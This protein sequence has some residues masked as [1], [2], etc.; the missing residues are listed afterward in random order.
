MSTLTI[1][2]P[3]S[4]LTILEAEA[5]EAY[6]E[7]DMVKR[8]HHILLEALLTSK[9]A[10]NAD[11]VNVLAGLL[12]VGATGNRMSPPVAKKNQFPALIQPTTVKQLAKNDKGKPATPRAKY[13][14]SL[15]PPNKMFMEKV[16]TQWLV[17]TFLVSETFDTHMKWFSI[18]LHNLS[19]KIQGIR[20]TINSALESLVTKGWLTYNSVDISK[21]DRLYLFT[22][23][24]RLWLLDRENQSWL[25]EQSVIVDASHAPKDINDTYFDV[26]G[27]ETINVTDYSF[28]PAGPAPGDFQ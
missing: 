27:K 3:E 15:V 12:S 25:I 1:N 26:G 7:P 2:L 17:W 22:R 13:Q 19:G 28:G 8:A 14:S 23:D 20:S 10:K 16:N 6:G 11:P 21:A 5:T 18:D 9:H 24:A 4:L